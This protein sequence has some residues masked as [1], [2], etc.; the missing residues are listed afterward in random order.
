VERLIFVAGVPALKA[1]QGQETLLI[2]TAQIL[3]TTPDKMEKVASDLV[4]EKQIL[5]K[6]V[7]EFRAESTTR[8]AQMLL[9]ASRK[10]G[11]LKLVSSKRTSGTED[12]LIMLSSKVVEAEPSTVCVLV[13][14]KENVRIFVSAGK[15]ALKAGVNAGELANKLA[16][17]VGGGG[18]GKPY[19][20]Q[21][22]GTDVKKAD[23]VLT[24]VRKLLHRKKGSS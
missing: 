12:D 23:E 3:E 16:E 11:R 2:R 10:V 7:E 15:Q 13:L 24:A 22:G 17:I 9:M 19:F 5:A 8:E 4:A 21:G 20:G 14:V 1:I 18:G 6:K